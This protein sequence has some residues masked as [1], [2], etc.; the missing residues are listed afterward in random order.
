MRFFTVRRADDTVLLFQ[1]LDMA[2]PAQTSSPGRSAALDYPAARLRVAGCFIRV[3]PS[4]CVRAQKTSQMY[5]S[6]RYHDRFINNTPLNYALS[7]PLL[8]FAAA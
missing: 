2:R 1:V 5:P 7:A 4:T 3:C 8:P 6:E